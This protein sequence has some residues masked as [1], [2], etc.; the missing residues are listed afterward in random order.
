MP[1][2]YPAQ[3]TVF[4]MSRGL[5]GFDSQATA[6]RVSNV[7]WLQD[8]TSELVTAITKRIEMITGL[9]LYNTS[10]FDNVT[11]YSSDDLQVHTF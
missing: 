8:S 6:A 1:Y 9:E 5:V 3:F 7:G 10:I 11:Y 4:Q 2:F